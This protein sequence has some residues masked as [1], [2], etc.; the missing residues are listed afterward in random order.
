MELDIR[1]GTERDV[2]VILDLI[3][4]LAEYEKLSH[5]VLA[6]EERL[7]AS[8]FGQEPA[9]E[10]LIGFVGSEPVGL[11]LFFP[12]FSTFLGQPGLYIEDLFVAP[13]WRRRGFGQQLMRR[14]AAIAVERA[15]GRMEWA[16]LNWN[17]PAI[18]FYKALEAQPM[19][20]WTVH[21]LTGDSLR[22]FASEA[23]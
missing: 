22:G 16:V 6:T 4:G 10:V 23:R 8:L 13:A 14:V 12:T 20:D 5:E 9:G 19:N 17:A 11:A 21:R 15:Y 18:E 7:R 1:H 2:P 3:K